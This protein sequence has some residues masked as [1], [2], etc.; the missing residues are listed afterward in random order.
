M[1]M[2]TVKIWHIVS[3]TMFMAL[4][5]FVQSSIPVEAARFGQGLFSPTG[6]KF[7]E[8]TSLSIS[9]GG[10]VSVNLSGVSTFTGQGSHTIQVTTND[11]VGYQLYVYSPT[12]T[13]MTDGSGLSIPASANVSAAALAA[14]TWGYNIDGSTTNYIG[15]TT[16]PKLLKNDP[17]VHTSAVSTGVYYGVKTDLTQGSGTYRINVIYTAISSNE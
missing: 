5:L 12:S 4:L 17:G 16:T 2:F 1:K 3:A 13:N 8:Q 6:T 11:V 7:G 15:M 10:N 9:L 14:N